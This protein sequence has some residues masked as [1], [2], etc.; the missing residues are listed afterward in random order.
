MYPGMSTSLA[1]K[2][3]VVALSIA[4][5]SERLGYI[6]LGELVDLDVILYLYIMLCSYFDP[7]H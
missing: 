7:K 2:N 5:L 4:V 1:L 3:G 6:V